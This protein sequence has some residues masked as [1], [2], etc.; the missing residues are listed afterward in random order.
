MPVE[1]LAYRDVN[2]I[3]RRQAVRRPS[4]HDPRVVCDALVRITFH[5]PDWRWVQGH[6]LRLAQH[7]S[8]DVRGLAATCLGHL[9]RVHRALDLEL[10]LPVLQE[11]LLD[12]DVGGR[13]ENALADIAIYMGRGPEDVACN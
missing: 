7:P 3:S 6:C 5:N 11:M 8:A 13:A 1:R 12:H 10:V 9:A 4:G 2:P